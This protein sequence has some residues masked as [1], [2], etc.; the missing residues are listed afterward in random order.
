MPAP[1]S[2]SENARRIDRLGGGKLPIFRV[3]R[4]SRTP[5][6]YSN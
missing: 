4:E 6:R 3:I 5:S 1:F 2:F